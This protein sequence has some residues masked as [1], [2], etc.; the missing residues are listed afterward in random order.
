MSLLLTAAIRS[1]EHTSELQSRFDLVCRLLLE[2]KNIDELPLVRSKL[3][4]LQQNIS[5]HLHLQDDAQPRA[6]FD[7]FAFLVWQSNP[8]RKPT[9]HRCN[10]TTRHCG[11]SGMP[12]TRRSVP[13]LSAADTTIAISTSVRC[14]SAS[15]SISVTRSVPE[16]DDLTALRLFFF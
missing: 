5:G 1:E 10:S 9:G 3:P 8:S 2:K 4:R 13:S 16:V 6:D 12:R 15:A 11:W 7:S 14:E